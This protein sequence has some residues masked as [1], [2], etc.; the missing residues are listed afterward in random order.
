MLAEV[1]QQNEA[2]ILA[3]NERIIS[4]AQQELEDRLVNGDVQIVRTKDGTEERRVPVKA[5]DLSVIGGIAY[6]KRRLSLSL[7]TSIRADSASLEKLAER[8]EDIAAQHKLR[9]ITSIP[10]SCEQIDD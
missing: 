4:L 9:R 1:R 8:F 2:M 3:G 10:G 6:D 5:R 7:P